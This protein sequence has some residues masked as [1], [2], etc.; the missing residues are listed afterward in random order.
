M[1]R[2]TGQ[3]KGRPPLGDGDRILSLYRQGLTDR[4]VAAQSGRSHTHCQRQ[5][6]HAIALMVKGG[7][8]HAEIAAETGRGIGQVKAIIK[9]G[10]YQ[11]PGLRFH[12]E[13][14]RL[15]AAGTRCPACGRE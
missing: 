4:Q 8:S 1:T 3:P 15:Y 11:P 2:P 10:G 14:A 9:A 5:L 7:M 12:D 6:R 13:C